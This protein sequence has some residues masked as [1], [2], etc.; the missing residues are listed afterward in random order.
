MGDL[1]KLINMNYFPELIEVFTGYW[2]NE[3]ILFQL[4]IVEIT[5]TIEEL[6]YSVDKVTTCLKK[7]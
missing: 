1:T 5:L 4:R 2:D 3:K 6:W 7:E